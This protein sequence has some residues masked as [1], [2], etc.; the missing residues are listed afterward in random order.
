LAQ[1][2]DRVGYSSAVVR[3]RSSDLAPRFLDEI[4][5]DARF[6]LK[7]QTE[8]RYWA[9]QATS[10]ATFVRVLGLFVSI[11][12]SVGAVTGAMITMYA[13]VAARAR[14]LAM[15]RAI[16]FRARSVLGS[17]VLEAALLGV[18]GGVLG[19]S[20]ALVM[21][22]VHIQT[23]N[24][25]TFSEVRFRF[26]PTF[27][28]LMSALSFGVVMGTLGGVLPAFRAARAPILESMRR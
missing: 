4:A 2:F 24:F 22:W 6:T 1:A 16:G 7:A 17:V 3:L 25:Q 20:G 21:R 19:A 8:D 23:L 13:Q 15:M 18:A 9:S 11:V 10:T 12:F 14:E 27:P 28:I 5:A 26:V